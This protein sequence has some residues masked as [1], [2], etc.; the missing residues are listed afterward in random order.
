[1]EFKLYLKTV[2][3]FPSPVG[4]LSIEL[5]LDLEYLI[6]FE[7]FLE[8][9]KACLRNSTDHHAYNLVNSSGTFVHFNVEE[10]WG[11]T[12][13]I[14]AY[15]KELYTEISGVFE[16]Y[17]KLQEDDEDTEEMEKKL[18]DMICKY[19][20][21]SSIVL[22]DSYEI[23]GEDFSQD[24]FF[25]NLFEASDNIT[26]ISRLNTSE[27]DALCVYCKYE[28]EGLKYLA[29][30][31]MRKFYEGVNVYG[32]KED[33]AR[34]QISESIPDILEP[35]INWDGVYDDLVNGS[36]ASIVEGDNGRIYEFTNY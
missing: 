17:K 22:G 20:N 29:N 1:M 19:F 2:R 26:G 13:E 14:T 9:L 4:P 10:A 24:Q 31:N 28:N 32:D 16:K 8:E 5:E 15:C 18:P 23:V 7:S 30:V 11:E 25:Q 27:E 36:G 3:Q 21:L 35:N 34:S 33:F 12:S 6:D